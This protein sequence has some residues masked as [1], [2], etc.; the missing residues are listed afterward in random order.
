MPSS[1]RIQLDSKIYRSR[2][3]GCLFGLAIGDAFG[4]AA[5]DPENQFLYGITMDWPEKPTFSTDDTEFA[6]LSAEILIKS[7]GKPTPEHVLAAWKEHVVV[8]DELKRGGGSERDAATNIRRGLKAPE[9]GKFNAYS[10]SDGAA[11]RSAPMGIVAAGNP[12]LA[13]EMA[14]V[15][16][17][18][19]HAD[20]GIWGAQAVAAAVA[21]SMAGG[22]VDDII[23]EARRWAPA[24]S[25]FKHS[26]DTAFGILEEFDYN[27]ERSWM[28]LHKAIRCEYKASVP[29]AVVSAFAVFKL[30]EGKFKQGMIHAGNFGRDTDTI[31]AIVGALAGASKGIGVI[32]ETWVKNVQKPHGTCLSFTAE[33]DLFE[34]AYKLTELLSIK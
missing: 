7:N 12:D 22:G 21:V 17:E 26:F 20:D 24:G 8:E 23:A 32:P 19:S 9:T 18:I 16:A 6:L 33:Q 5:R 1:D 2:A 27:I 29:E 34:V 15:D 28:P 25:W 3:A 30:T 13:A 4:D 31:G 11:M 10:K 14:R